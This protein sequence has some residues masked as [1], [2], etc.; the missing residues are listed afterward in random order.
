MCI[1]PSQTHTWHNINL[2][3]EHAC[4]FME[5]HEGQGEMP[6]EECVLLCK[7]YAHG[8]PCYYYNHQL[9]NRSRTLPKL[10]TWPML[11]YMHNQQLPS[12]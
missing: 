6:L 4:P 7:R 8:H 11:L 1:M 9:P 5:V 10:S 2:Q 3:I 12:S